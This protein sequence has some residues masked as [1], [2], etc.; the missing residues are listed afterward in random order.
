M[1]HFTRGNTW[2]RLNIKKVDARRWN[3]YINA[4]PL[5]VIPLW[6][7][8]TSF[9]SIH[10]FSI[11][12]D[13]KKKKNHRGW[14]TSEEREREDILL[15]LFPNVTRRW[16]SLSRRPAKNT[17]VI[18]LS[19]KKYK[20][21]ECFSS[22]LRSLPFARVS[23]VFSHFRP[24]YFS[25]ASGFKQRPEVEYQIV[26]A[27]KLDILTF[28]HKLSIF[29]YYERTNETC[30]ISIEP[31]KL[32]ADIHEGNSRESGREREREREKDRKWDFF[33]DTLSTRLLSRGQKTNGVVI[34]LSAESLAVSSSV[35]NLPPP[36]PFTISSTV[37][38]FNPSL[39]RRFPFFFF[40][41]PLFFFHF[42]CSGSTV[43]YI[44][45]FTSDE[46]PTEER[47][48]KNTGQSHGNRMY[49]PFCA[50]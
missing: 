10:L 19:C 49:L 32:E 43:W 16:R 26:V 41:P 40:S 33:I 31:V 44:M 18:I 34:I 50:C 45:Y 12:L 1:L 17:V 11:F 2:K 28:F 13:K 3:T 35:L 46:P 30:G 47:T 21:V 25:R 9:G 22:L 15:R 48:T 27:R 38:G 39:L 42:S 5:V 36:G 37:G 20:V 23:P 24:S 4:W 8:H 7:R 29:S 14:T 6:Q